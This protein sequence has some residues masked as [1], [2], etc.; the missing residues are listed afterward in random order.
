MA[1]GDHAPCLPF[2]LASSLLNDFLN[3][4]DHFKTDWKEKKA[5]PGQETKIKARQDSA[6]GCSTWQYLANQ[7]LAFT[8]QPVTMHVTPGQL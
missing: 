8:G 7:L 4:V 5:V 3:S 2:Y 1:Q 6:A